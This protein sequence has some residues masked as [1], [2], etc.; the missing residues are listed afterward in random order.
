[1]IE[2]KN[3]VDVFCFYLTW[4]GLT[5]HEHVSRHHLRFSQISAQ[6]DL[7]YGNQVAILEKQLSAVTPEQCLDHLHIL[8]IGTS[9]KDT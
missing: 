4:K 5:L 6:S 8:I 9:N 7:K 3:E 1:M 2:T